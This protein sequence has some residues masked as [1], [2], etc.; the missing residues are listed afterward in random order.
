MDDP[1][2]KERQAE[3][4]TMDVALG[5]I[6]ARSDIVAGVGP[7]I[8]GDYS[9]I[10]RE[11]FAPLA[12]TSLNEFLRSVDPERLR[13]VTRDLSALIQSAPQSRVGGVRRK[14][15]AKEAFGLG[16]AALAAPK[17]PKASSRD[18]LL[19]LDLGPGKERGRSLHDLSGMA[20]SSPHNAAARWR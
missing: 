6:H 16:R 20:Q 13:T 15:L 18:G 5:F 10:L 8:S 11:T 7:I 12:D 19:D 4:R 1:K 3:L 14:T 9:S 17:R 2:I